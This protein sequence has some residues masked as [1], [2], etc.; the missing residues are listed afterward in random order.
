MWPGVLRFLRV[1]FACLQLTLM[2]GSGHKTWIAW[3]LE[4]W[5]GWWKGVLWGMINVL[6]VL[7]QIDVCCVSWSV[8]V[9][10]WVAIEIV[11]E[12]SVECSRQTSFLLQLSIWSY[13]ANR[14]LLV[15]D[16]PPP[17]WTPTHPHQGLMKGA[18]LRYSHIPSELRIVS[19]SLCEG[20]RFVTRQWCTVGIPRSGT[21]S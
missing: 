1:G 20:I 10:R 8:G 13:T 21:R 12:W 11:G 19:H 16:P 3:W 7:Q 4:I 2:M 15:V 9:C 14:E 18:R 6:F 5:F 17:P